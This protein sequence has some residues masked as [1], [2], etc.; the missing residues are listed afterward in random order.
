MSE[1]AIF[2]Y[3]LVVF[4]IVSAACWLIIWG[5][6]EE[7]RDRETLDAGPNVRAAA[8]GSGAAAPVPPDAAA[9]RTGGES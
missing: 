1:V 5:I 4:A 6:F 8:S 9:G 3:G 7:R 2:L